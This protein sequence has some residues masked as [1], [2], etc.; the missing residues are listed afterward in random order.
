MEKLASLEH[1]S[2][3]PS[4]CILAPAAK[5]EKESEMSM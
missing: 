2:Y 4:R 1:K 5:K 3:D